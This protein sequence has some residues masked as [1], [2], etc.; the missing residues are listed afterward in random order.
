MTHHSFTP[1]HLACTCIY[2]YVH[3]DL[4]DAFDETNSFGVTLSVPSLLCGLLHD[5]FQY[6]SVHPIPIDFCYGLLRY[7]LTLLFCFFCRWYVSS[8]LSC[9]NFLRFESL[10]PAHL[11]IYYSLISATPACW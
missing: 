11:W 8:S 4:S 5:V 2:V 3:A 10:S 9:S 7:A 1:V 6:V